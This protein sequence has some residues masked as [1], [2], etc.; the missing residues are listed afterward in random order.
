MPVAEAQTNKFFELFASGEPII[1]TP[2]KP[3]L[4]MPRRFLA[5]GGRTN[6][7][8]GGLPFGNRP[9]FGPRGTNDFQRRRGDFTLM[10]VAAPLRDDGG[11]IC[12]ALALVINPTNEFTR[13]LS[14]ARSGES[15]ETYAFDQTGLLISS[16]RFD[17]QLRRLGLLTSSN[18]SS[19]LNLRLHDPGGDLTKGF[20]PETNS[21]AKPLDRKSVV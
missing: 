2:F 8:G 13:I 20:K 9:Q 6:E 7:F 21:A 14:V 16:S 17:V 5:P 3:E 1:I 12:G 11:V 19:A 10:Q 4:T 18:S 15:G